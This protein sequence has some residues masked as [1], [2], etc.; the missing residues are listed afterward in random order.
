MGMDVYIDGELTIPASKL[1]EARDLLLATMATPHGYANTQDPW[2]PGPHDTFETPEQIF[3][4]IEGRLE[5]IGAEQ[6]SDGSIVF[7]L[8][9]STRHED[10]DEWLF[11]AL[12]PAFEDGE[13]YLRGDEYH[14]KWVIEDGEFGTV[15]GQITFSHDENAVP[16]INALI[17]LMYPEHL[18]GNPI[19]LSP[20]GFSGKV[21]EFEEVLWKIENLLREGGYGPQAGKNELDRLAEI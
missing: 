16:T 21:A 15:D 9:D 8:E 1:T 2:V 20:E 5:R 19:T 12:A 10:Y 3:G 17:E 4:L 13:F 6:E 7:G 18:K 14:W 11:E